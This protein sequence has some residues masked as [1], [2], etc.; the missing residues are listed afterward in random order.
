MQSHE[1]RYFLGKTACGAPHKR[2]IY[3]AYV[4]WTLDDKHFA[5]CGEIWNSK[6]TCIITGGQCLDTLRAL[7]P[8]DA[9]FQRMY[10]I[11][12][13]WHLND[14]RAG[15]PAQMACLEACKAQ[16][17]G[18]PMSQYDWAKTVLKAH[19]L[20]PD[21]NYTH[22]GKYRPMHSITNEGYAYGSRWLYEPLP[23][24][25]RAEI[26]SWDATTPGKEEGQ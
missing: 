24:E 9:K 12:Q 3:E 10:D 16:Y 8:D 18:Y 7:F 21:R 25:V 14:L 4:T 11:W 2:R 19:N 15:T 20:D 17:P 5:M 13:R 26:E 23:A 1:H 22:E 6:K